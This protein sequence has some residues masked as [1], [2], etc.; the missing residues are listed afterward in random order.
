MPFSLRCSSVLLWLIAIL[1]IKASSQEPIRFPRTPDISPDGKLVAFSYLGDIWTVETIGGVAR[2]VT[3]HE[4][5]DINPCFSPDGRWLAFSSNRHGSYDVFVVPAHGGKPRRVTFDS[6]QD[7]VVGWTPDGKSILFNST[8][9]TGFPAVPEVYSVPVEGGRERLLP[10]IEA[11]EASYSP[12]GNLV[13]FTRGPGIWYRKGYRGSSNDDIWLA[14]PDGTNVHRLTSFNGQDGSPQWS[15]DGRKIY[16]V[17]EQFGGPA[18]IVSLDLDSAG[19]PVGKPFSI[20]NHREDAVRRARISAN[21]EWI[22]YECGGD[23]WLVGTKG[24]TPRKLAIEVHADEKSNGERM[25]TYTRDVSEYSLSPDDTHVA[26]VV[27]G[28][29][30]LMPAKGGKATRLTD[31][32][33]VEQGI[34]WSNDGKAILFAADRNGQEDLYLLEPDDPEHPEITKAHRFKSKQLTNTPEAE[35]GATF[36]PDGSKILFLR[37]GKLW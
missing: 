11:K 25:T 12:S 13:S 10:F 15:P 37:G 6:A 32:P 36:A 35:S 16:Y 14:K 2:P 28:E 5:H 4:A 1:P 19:L 27:H 23:L 22:V 26:F 18:N 34:S 9:A 20:T 17:S 29:I 24:G 30:F 33:A 31:T 7:M 8:R 21:G 3:M